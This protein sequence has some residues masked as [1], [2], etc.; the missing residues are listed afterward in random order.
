MI[1]L[2]VNICDKKNRHSVVS[3]VGGRIISVVPPGSGIRIGWSL[4]ETLS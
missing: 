2:G 1:A 3:P 4:S